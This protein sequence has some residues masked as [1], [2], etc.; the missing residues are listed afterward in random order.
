[1]EQEIDPEF[2]FAGR[3]AIKRQSDIDEDI[4]RALQHHYDESHVLWRCLKR[5]IGVNEPSCLS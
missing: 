4:E 5:G 1:M 2:S 3:S